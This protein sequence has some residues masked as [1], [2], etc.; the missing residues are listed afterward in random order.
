MNPV[1]KKEIIGKTD[2]AHAIAMHTKCTI[3]EAQSVIER[4]CNTLTELI[5]QNK[6]ISIKG[7]GSFNIS[8]SKERNGIN[9]RTLEKIVIPASKKI[10]FKAS[11]TLKE[12]VMQKL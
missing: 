10:S 9:P 1:Q 5:R 11:A 7:F 3:T 2:L 6:T 4:F 8:E 12:A